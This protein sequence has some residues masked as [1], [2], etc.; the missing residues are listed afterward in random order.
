M[1]GGF[2]DAVIGGGDLEDLCV[3]YTEFKRHVKHLLALSDVEI[4]Q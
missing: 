3:A 4:K 2:V 1:L